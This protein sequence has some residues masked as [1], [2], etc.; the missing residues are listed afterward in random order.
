MKPALRGPRVVLRTAE[1]SDGPRLL[2][3][4]QEPEVRRFWVS[5]SE[6]ADLLTQ[7]TPDER[8]RAYAITVDGEVIGW[9]G[10]AELLDDDYR[11]AGIDLF[12]TSARRGQG[13]GPEAITLACRELF[14]AARHHRITIDPSAENARAIRA[15]EKVGFRRVGVMRRYERG[16]DGTFHDGV[17]ME[18]IHGE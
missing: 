13:F 10:A 18:L 12:L 6:V 3:I 1:P 14:E 8:L 7:E 11:H 5:D 16:R 2:A 15:Y 17:L 9:L 4:Q